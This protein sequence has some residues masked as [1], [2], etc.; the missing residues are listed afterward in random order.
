[1]FS[2]QCALSLSIFLLCMQGKQED[3]IPLNNLLLIT[4]DGKLVSKVEKQYEFGMPLSD[5][6]AAFKRDRCMIYKWGARGAIVIDRHLPLLVEKESRRD[7]IKSLSEYVGRDLVVR[8][9]DVPEGQRQRFLDAIEEFFPWNTRPH[10]FD[11]REAAVGVDLSLNVSISGVGAS[12]ARK[13][14]L[15]MP[16]ELAKRRNHAL[17]S[18]LMPQRDRELSDEEQAR[19]KK[20]NEDRAS[21]LEQLNLRFLGTARENVVDGLR[22]SAVLLEQLLIEV[23]DQAKRAAQDLIEK[24]GFEPSITDL[25][26]GKIRIEDLP[27]GIRDRLVEQVNAEWKF[28]GYDSA[29]DAEKSLLESSS[30]ELSI[31]LG[32][33]RT[34][35]ASDR[36]KGRPSSGM[37]YNFILIRN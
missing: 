29:H 13:V 5:F 3:S 23:N 18:H 32:L 7:L 24:V 19:V 8:V 15:P 27:A 33:R 21:S 34:F 17:E 30:V 2:M 36:Q 12:N 4:A 35:S 20:Q 28:L 25:P 26:K 37:V 14:V 6:S 1:M 31:N 11:M 9:G 22:E 16:P 10:N